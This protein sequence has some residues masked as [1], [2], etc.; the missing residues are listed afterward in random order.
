M[1]KG[2]SE[3]PK[4]IIKGVDGSE[5]AVPFRQ[6]MGA[7]RETVDAAKSVGERAEA[8]PWEAWD[9]EARLLYTVKLFAA[10]RRTLQEPNSFRSLIYDGL[11][12]GPDAYAPLYCAGA[13]DVNNALVKQRP[14]EEA[15]RLHAAD[16]EV[17]A[18]GDIVVTEDVALQ[19]QKE[20]DEE[21]PT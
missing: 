10:L 18:A 7:V 19:G 9:Y 14:T 20:P 12:F 5:E 3:D 2:Q 11:G 1:P 13:M 17:L 21:A 4:L 6:F 8:T 16:E 15:P